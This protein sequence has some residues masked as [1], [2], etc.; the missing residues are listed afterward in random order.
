MEY[1]QLI[2]NET[3]YVKQKSHF[4]QMNMVNRE[5]L[6]NKNV[7]LLNSDMTYIIS[8]IIPEYF[9]WT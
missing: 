2:L 1:L 4:H 9:I 8:T 5:S 7:V 3:K 6:K